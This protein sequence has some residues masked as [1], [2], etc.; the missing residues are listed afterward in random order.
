MIKI[1]MVGYGAYVVTVEKD[2][3]VVDAGTPRIGMYNMVPF[4]KKIN[5][6][7]IKRVFVTHYHHNHVGGVPAL[8]RNFDVE[9]VQ[10]NGVYSDDQGA[11]YVKADPLAKEELLRVIDYKKTPYLF[12]EHGN[13]YDDKNVT[14]QIWRPKSEEN[15][16]GYT[17]N[18]NRSSMM[19][20]FVYEDFSI[21][22]GGDLVVPALYEE[23]YAQLGT[24]PQATVFAHPH[25]GDRNAAV[26]VVY[27]PINPR[28]ALIEYIS[29]ATDT[30]AY[31]DSKDIEHVQLP[32]GDKI[33]KTVTGFG[34][35]TYVVEEDVNIPRLGWIS[36]SYN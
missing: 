29:S 23:V 11:S 14:I 21:L 33:I 6:T 35:G 32:A 12:E 31:L 16:G 28:L 5:V 4:L 7:K 13:E 30:K 20:R 18:P 24:V 27:D 10:T 8:I 22:F 1:Y 17:T 2:V 3:Y 25:H 9:V 34:D 19:C 26:D 15:P 36:P